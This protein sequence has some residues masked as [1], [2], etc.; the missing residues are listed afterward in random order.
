MK[1]FCFKLYYSEHNYRLN[2]QINVAG[3]IYNHCIALHKRYYRLYGK[4]LD[5]NKLQK[6]LVKLK[7]HKRFAYICEI[8]SQAVQDITDRI[9]RAYNLFWSNLK[10]K[11]KCSPPK[12]RKVR[13]YKSYTLKQ[14]G[15]K[16][17]ETKGKIRIGKKWYGYFQ[18]RNIEGKIKTVTI[19]RDRVGDIYIYLVCDTQCDMVKPRM[20]KSVGFGRAARRRHFGL[21]KFLTGSDGKDIKSPYFFMLNIKTIRKKSRNLSSK[22]EG[23]HNRNRARKAL[24]RAYRKMDNQRKDFHFKTARR[25]C[26]EYA[27]ICLEDLNIKGMARRWGRKVHSL[28]FYNFVQILNYEALKL[29]TQIIFVDRYFPSSQLCSVCGYKNKAVKDLKIREWEC[30]NCHTLHN[31]DKNAAKNILMAGA[32]AI[33]G[34]PVPYGVQAQDILRSARFVDTRIARL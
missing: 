32:S 8:G 30:P 34:E 27:V 31:R 10:R 4:Y 2:R 13:K 17:D 18:S 15:W 22:K 1:T 14:A 12:F 3:F 9:E 16:L 7:K 25:L 24:A 6:H 26:E 20:G 19:K 21:K 11:K 23:S 33:G 29:G 28:G 5:K